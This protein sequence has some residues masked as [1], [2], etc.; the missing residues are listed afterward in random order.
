MIAPASATKTSGTSER[1][2]VSRLE[3]RSWPLAE[4]FTVSLRGGAATLPPV[5]LAAPPW[6]SP[7]TLNKRLKGAFPL[8]TPVPYDRPMPTKRAQ[9]VHQNLVS[10]VPVAPKSDAN[11]H[12]VDL[13]VHLGTDSR[14]PPG[15]CLPAIGKGRRLLSGVCLR[16]LGNERRLPSGGC[17]RPI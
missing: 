5:A 13:C 9:G 3:G 6:A 7:D 2:H 11:I 16:P 14:F 17:L 4:S 1:R 12:L 10:C 8:K 15:R